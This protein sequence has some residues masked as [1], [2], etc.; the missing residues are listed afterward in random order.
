MVLS[1]SVSCSTLEHIWLQTQLP[2][3]TLT[4]NLNAMHANHPSTCNIYHV[5]MRTRPPIFNLCVHVDIENGGGLGLRPA[6]W[7]IW[8]SDADSHTQLHEGFPCL[9]SCIHVCVHRVLMV[10]FN[11]QLNDSHMY[12]VLIHIHVQQYACSIGDIVW[13]RIGSLASLHRHLWTIVN[14]PP[15]LL[16]SVLE[17]PTNRWYWV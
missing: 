2:P 6:I 12:T 3:P 10:D 13:N 14:E 4:F 16:Y 5:T 17:P 9:S 8:H 1:Y 11:F 15:N 7:Y